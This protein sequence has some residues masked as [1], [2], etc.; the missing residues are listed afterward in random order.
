MTLQPVVGGVGVSAAGSRVSTKPS[1]SR[2]MI[3]V[4]GSMVVVVI[5]VVVGVVVMAGV[6]ND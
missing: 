4:V 2:M 5:T 1:S 3:T 6:M